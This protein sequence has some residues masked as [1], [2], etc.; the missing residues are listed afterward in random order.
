[1]GAKEKTVGGGGATP[2]AN[3]WN[4]WLQSQLGSQAGGNALGGQN[5]DQ[6]KNALR[7]SGMPIGIQ[8]QIMRSWDASAATQGNRTPASTTPSTFQN[9]VNG[10]A[11]G[12]VNDSTGAQGILQ[13]ILSG[14][15]Q[16]SPQYTN[17][18]T[19]PEFSGPKLSNLP[20]DM[21][22]GQTGMADLSRVGRVGDTN[23]NVMQG[24]G[25]G[26]TGTSFD[27]MLAQA[28]QRA[29]QGAPGVTSN[30][31]SLAPA[32][33]IDLNNPLVNAITQGQERS[34][35]IDVANLRARFGAEGAGSMGTGAQVGEATLAAEYAPRIAAAQQ[36]AIQFQQQQDL[37]E[38]TAGANV[39]LGSNAQGIQAG[40]ANAGNSI[41]S[42]GNLLQSILS[43]RQ[44]DFTQATNNRES[45]LDNLRLALGQAQGNQGAGI[46]QRGQDLS[47]A[48][49]NQGQG[50][51][52]ALG[53]G[54]QNSSNM[55]AN[56]SNQL[57][58]SRL[59]NGFNQGNAQ[60]SA[61][62]QLS[63]NTLNASQGQS[64]QDR[65]MQQLMAGLQ[66]NG[67]GNNNQ[68]AILQMLFGGMQQSNGL[69]TPQ[70][71][72]LMEQNPWMQALQAGAGLAGQY[73]GAPRKG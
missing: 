27:N 5:L 32:A 55:Q 10:A 69:G 54:A 3:D 47:S 20:T 39:A 42:S 14:G 56:N 36:Q 19:S 25:T 62:G 73:A 23:V 6:A 37:A 50:N 63:T 24:Y 1:M 33:Q 65:F 34:K 2:V 11:S 26:A 53:A 43:G 61:S 9:L 17:P 72:S 60:N 22:S 45:D 13:R 21:F 59:L 41:A 48:L 4:S 40:T 66:Q 51:Q 31:T 44:Q 12:N 58:F 28:M 64:D 8:E 29:G 7:N 68:M 38:R 15:V 18:Y 67:V 49:T 57:D 70:A 35:M 16:N 71:Q 30:S 46:S 52:F